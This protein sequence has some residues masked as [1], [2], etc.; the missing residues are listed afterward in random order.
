MIKERN[1]SKD[2]KQAKYE[3]IHL[4]IVWKFMETFIRAFLT[5]NKQLYCFYEGRLRIQC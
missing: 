4:N 2:I 5:E 3:R 1:D